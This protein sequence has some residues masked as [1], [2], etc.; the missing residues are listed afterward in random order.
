MPKEP[1]VVTLRDYMYPTRTAQPSSI[2]LPA[3]NATFEQKSGL[4]PM[5]PVFYGMDK[6]NPY[7]HVREIED[8]CG[9]MK[10][11]QMIK[12]PFSFK[13]KAKTWLY[14]QGPLPHRLH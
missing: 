9:T 8:I 14:E 4:L 7:Q 10:Y 13:E 6:E 12:F 3:T 2:T 11:I 5:L 1:Q